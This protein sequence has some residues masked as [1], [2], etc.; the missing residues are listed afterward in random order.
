MSA[1]T[2][3]NE[4]DPCSLSARRWGLIPDVARSYRYA[5]VLVWNPG[6][7]CGYLPQKFGGADFVFSG[8]GGTPASALNTPKSLGV[9]PGSGLAFPIPRLA[10]GQRR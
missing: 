6:D 3:E 8:P 9:P 7:Q 10:D 2:N 4:S 1:I 5:A